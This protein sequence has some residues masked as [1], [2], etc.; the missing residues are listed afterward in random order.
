LPFCHATLKAQKPLPP[1]YPNS[2]KT[3]GDHLRKR[4]LDL[5]L[6]QKDV[7]EK[8]GVAEATVWY[9]EKNLTSPSLRYIPKIIKFLGYEPYDTMDKTLGQ[10][11]T[12]A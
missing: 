10:G 6:R 12:F 2:L 11:M 3:L 8:L 4:R 9:W 1:A 5:S 7:S